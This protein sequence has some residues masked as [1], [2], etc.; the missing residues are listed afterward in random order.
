MF[1]VLSQ[2]D[3]MKGRLG[4]PMAPYT[5]YLIFTL[6]HP[7]LS[8]LCFFCFLVFSLICA[9]VECTVHYVLIYLL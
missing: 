9:D 3:L 8:N 4:V 6:A 7:M 1:G 2:K 5:G